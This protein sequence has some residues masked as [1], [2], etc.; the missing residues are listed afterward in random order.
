MW[1]GLHMSRRL[2]GTVTTDR[3][4]GGKADACIP[5]CPRPSTPPRYLFPFS[6]SPVLDHGQAARVVVSWFPSLGRPRQSA[7][8]VN[9]HPLPSTPS[10]GRRHA[11]GAGSTALPSAIDGIAP[12]PGDAVTGRKR[13]ETM[14]IGA[15]GNGGW[16]RWDVCRLGYYYCCAR[17]HGFFLLF[18]FFFFFFFSSHL[19]V[20]FVSASASASASSW[21]S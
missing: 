6:M 18:F 7:E 1:F 15:L 19:T 8:W 9:S 17:D 16:G 4:G 21:C 10:E 3:E 20:V 14:G 13:G 5:Y 2:R 11:G 12:D